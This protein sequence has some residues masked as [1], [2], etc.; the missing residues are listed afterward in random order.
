MLLVRESVGTTVTRRRT[1][2]DFQIENLIPALLGLGL[3]HLYRRVGLLQVSRPQ[4]L[5]VMFLA[6]AHHPPVGCREIRCVLPHLASHT[7]SK[8]GTGVT[9][10]KPLETVRLNCI[11]GP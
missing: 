11:S 10:F 9:R 7:G 6:Q 4:E 5:L 2:D 8:D 3:S 1:E